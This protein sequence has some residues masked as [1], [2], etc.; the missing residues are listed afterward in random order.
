M[1]MMMMLLSRSTMMMTRHRA[2]QRHDLHHHHHPHHHDHHHAHEHEHAREHDHR[3]FMRMSMHNTICSV[4]L[5]VVAL[6]GPAQSSQHAGGEAPCCG[7]P[8]RTRSRHPRGCR[9]WHGRVW[10]ALAPGRRVGL[11][12]PAE[13]R[14]QQ[15]VHSGGGEAEAL[16]VAWAAES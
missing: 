2:R 8:G 5:S 1:L 10:R 11:Q 14:L 3:M 12:H 13:V 6:V 9:R 7:V 15:R 16:K 4:C